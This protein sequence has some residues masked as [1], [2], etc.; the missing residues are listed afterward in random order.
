MPDIQHVDIGP[1]WVKFGTLGSE[2]N[3]GWTKGGVKLAVDT[4]TTEI[5]VDQETDPVKTNITKRPITVSAPLAEF[6][7]E[8]LG[9]AL[10]GST[11]YTNKATLTT[12]LTGENN[13]LVFTAKTGGDNRGPGN[14][15]SIQ[16]VNPAALTAACS[17]TVTKKA[18][19]VTL[20][21]DGTNI[22][23]TASEVKTAIENSTAAAALVTVANAAENTGAGV[24]TAMAATFLTGGKQKLVVESAANEDLN[25]YANSLILHPTNREDADKSMDVWFPAAIPVGKFDVT[26]EK[27]NPKIITLEF[28]AFPDTSGKTLVIGDTTTTEA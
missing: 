7:L 13:D 25:D 27:E 2:T 18:I 9:F 19:A 20:K 5:E 10:P 16:Y 23:A 21:H 17:V 1:C 22:T 24:V 28:K 3:L 14:D 6:T 15:I 26:Y 12:N 4:Q 11:L 8:V